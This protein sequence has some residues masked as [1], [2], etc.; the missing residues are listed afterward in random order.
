MGRG[1]PGKNEQLL[2]PFEVFLVF[3]EHQSPAPSSPF[4][5]QRVAQSQIVPLSKLIG[6]TS[7]NRASSLSFCC[8]RRLVVKISL[9]TS[10]I[11]ALRS[12]RNASAQQSIKLRSGLSGLWPT[13]LAMSFVVSLHRARHSLM[14]PNWIAIAS[15]AARKRLGL[16]SMM[17]DA[18]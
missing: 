10:S 7:R 15:C 9:L 8:S 13:A 18:C 14:V 12:G 17:A 3:K 11:N 5:G 4:T 6:E 2:K 16:S 1:K